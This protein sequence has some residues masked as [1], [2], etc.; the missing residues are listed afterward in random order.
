MALQISVVK[1][2]AEIRRQNLELL[3]LEHG[4]LEAVAAA[5]ETSAVY[6]SQIRNQT[7]DP[8]TSKP[9]QMGAAIA[10]RLEIG[11]TK[12]SGWMD[13]SHDP[14]DLVPGPPLGGVARVPII[15]AITGKD[16][17]VEVVEPGER[18][19]YVEYPTSDG[20]A[21]SLRVRGDWAH[22]R[23]RAGEHLIV[24]PSMEP[25]EGDDVIVTLTDGRKLLMQLNWHRDNELQLLSLTPGNYSPTTLPM[26]DVVNIEVVGG[27][28]RRG[29]MRQP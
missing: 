20:K 6:L 1:P 25:Q 24:E 15:G 23:Y 8:K 29:A 21:Y 17:V 22:P 4:T 7:I 5:A 12:P 9:R 11:A 28:A 26:D 14:S 2:V 10:R 18:G 16:G 19:G 27:R 13:T 3:V